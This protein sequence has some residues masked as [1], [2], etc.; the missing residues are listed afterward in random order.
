MSQFEIRDITPDFGAEIVG[1][2]PVELDPEERD[3]LRR[4]FDERGLLV[5]RDLDIDRDYQTYLVDALIDYDRPADAVKQKQRETLVSNK[6]PEGNAPFGRLLFH[7]DMMW[8]AEPF[9]VLSLYGVEVQPPAV[10][11]AFV[12]TVAAWETLPKD[13]RQ[14]VENLHVVNVTGQQR[15]GD[16]EEEDLLQP[17]REHEQSVTTSVGH[18]HPRTNRTILYV[19]QMNTREIVE[20]SHDES[21]EL[22]EALFN[23]LYDP[24]HVFE[25]EWR[26]GDLAA[27]D[28][29]A[30]QHARATV[31]KE[32]PVRTLRK[33]ISPIPSMAGIETPKFSKVG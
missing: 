8:A 6:E 28:N 33:V 22:I 9:Q 29:L 30:I 25:H 13:L 15:R 16:E 32:G 7:S 21:E 14:R 4:T 18:A 11:T 24:A 19:S 12:S 26:E 5:F 27:W 31:K 3:L 1:F 23:H 17:I 2:E 20:L 10:P